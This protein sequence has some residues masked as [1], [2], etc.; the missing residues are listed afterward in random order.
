M[1]LGSEEVIQIEALERFWL[2]ILK[3]QAFRDQYHLID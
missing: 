1:N 2:S 3:N